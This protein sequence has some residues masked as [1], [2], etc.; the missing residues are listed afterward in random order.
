MPSRPDM[1]A[2]VDN[3]AEPAKGDA[4]PRRRC[5]EGSRMRGDDRDPP[6]RRRWLNV[7]AAAGLTALLSGCSSGIGSGERADP[8]DGMGRLEVSE[9]HRFFV[10]EVERPFF[11][12]AD[13]AW[14]LPINLDRAET[15]EYL[16]TRAEQGY[17]VIQTVAIFPQAGGPGPNRYGH[18]PFGAGLD[19]LRVT[20][21]S[22]PDEPWQ[23]DYWDHLDF[24]VDAAAERGLRVALVP[25]WASG[26]VGELITEENAARCVPGRRQP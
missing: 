12:L 2:A 17:N 6:R 24:V 15:I 3:P 18:N 21:G 14:S 19:D 23:Y 10:D 20:E 5:N 7:L 26:Q 22:D 16:D 8:S 9:N 11:W 13:T 1:I 25:V 4:Q